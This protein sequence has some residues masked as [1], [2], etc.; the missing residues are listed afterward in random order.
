MTHQNSAGYFKLDNKIRVRSNWKSP[1]IYNV[2]FCLATPG[3]TLILSATILA[4][5]QTPLP[6]SQSIHSSSTILLCVIV[7]TVMHHFVEVQQPQ[8]AHGTWLC[9]DTLS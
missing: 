7:G 8:L 4:S 1:Y 9:E 3:V 2:V 6:C 5:K